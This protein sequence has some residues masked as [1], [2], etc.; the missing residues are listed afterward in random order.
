MPNEPWCLP[1]SSDLRAGPSNV[2]V[3]AANPGLER[4]AF[5]GLDGN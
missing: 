4:V 2:L 3:M 5:V 1:L